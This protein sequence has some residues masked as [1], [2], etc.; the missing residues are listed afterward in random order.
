MENYYEILLI[1]I[2]LKDEILSETKKVEIC[3]GVYRN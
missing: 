3:W 2:M 1:K